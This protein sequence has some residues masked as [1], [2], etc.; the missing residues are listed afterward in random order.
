VLT[1]LKKTIR[2]QLPKRYQVPIKYINSLIRGYIEPELKLLKFIVNKDDLVLDVGGNRGIYSYVLWKLGCR[3]E[4][5]EPNPDCYSVLLSWAEKKRRVT[6]N[7]VGLSSSAGKV[8]LNI[9]VDDFGVSHD[10]SASIEHSSFKHFSSR[11]VDI[12]TLDRF[13]Y[14]FAF[15]KYV[16]FIPTIDFKDVGHLNV[17]GAEKLSLFMVNVIK[18][19]KSSYNELGE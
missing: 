16:D 10:A 15:N 12:K 4:V 17:N 1:R 2:D 8:E 13:Y 19:S 14:D 3:V 6:V 9:P 5:F 7:P 11:V 18:N